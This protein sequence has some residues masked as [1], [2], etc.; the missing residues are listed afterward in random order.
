VTDTGE[1]REVVFTVEEHRKILVSR[2]GKKGP[3][4]EVPSRYL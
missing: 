3:K 2:E 4:A 1:P